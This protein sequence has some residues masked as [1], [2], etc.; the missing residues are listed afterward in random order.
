MFFGISRLG[1]IEDKAIRE[2]SRVAKRTVQD[3]AQREAKIQSAGHVPD[4][5]EGEPLDGEEEGEVS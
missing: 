1:D 5:D 3:L 4:S 2:T